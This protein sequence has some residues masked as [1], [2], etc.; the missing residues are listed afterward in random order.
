MVVTSPVLVLQEEAEVLERDQNMV[1]KA[2][3]ER[4]TEL[5]ITARLLLA[6]V[7]QSMAQEDNYKLEEQ[8][9]SAETGPGGELG[10]LRE[11][12]EQLVAEQEKVEEA[13]LKPNGEDGRWKLYFWKVISEQLVVYSELKCR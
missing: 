7:A 1:A 3:M 10:A 13:V 4:Q 12:G 5:D 8:Q 9:A 2:T 11:L 6:V